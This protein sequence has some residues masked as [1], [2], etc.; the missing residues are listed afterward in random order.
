MNQT[1]KCH[2]AP[3]QSPGP[4]ALLLLC[5]TT[6][7]ASQLFSSAPFCSLDTYLICHNVTRAHLFYVH[8]IIY[9]EIIYSLAK[10]GRKF[11]GRQAIR[12]L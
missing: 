1:H 7:H 2:T 4:C 8:L 12:G 5:V 3:D 10:W 11:R 9:K 6:I